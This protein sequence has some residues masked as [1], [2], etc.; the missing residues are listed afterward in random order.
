MV[1]GIRDKSL[2]ER[3][4]LNSNLTIERAVTSTRQSGSEK[5]QQETFKQPVCVDAVK[6]TL[7]KRGSS[8]VVSKNNKSLTGNLQNKKKL[9]TCRDEQACKYCESKGHFARENLYRKA[10]YVNCH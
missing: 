5:R 3:L 1:V 10:F 2:S 7:N 9:K 8:S 6:R 4:Q